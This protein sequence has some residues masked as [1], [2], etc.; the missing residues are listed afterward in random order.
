MDE[1]SLAAK[2]LTTK[3]T[4][5]TALMAAATGGVWDTLA[6]DADPPFVVFEIQSPADVLVV[7]SQRLLVNLE[8]LV[9]VID[10]GDSYDDLDTAATRIYALLD[11]VESEP[12]YASD[13]VTVA[14][15]VS[16]FRT[17][18]YLDAYQDEVTKQQYRHKGGL[19]QIAVREA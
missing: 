11:R 15:D 17:E 5:D 14:A 2:W 3:L 19:Y 1:L 10:Q 4:G 7:G 8:A 16:C 13:G 12:V 9:R 6:G 18:A